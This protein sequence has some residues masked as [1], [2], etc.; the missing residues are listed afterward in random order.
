MYKQEEPEITEANALTVIAQELRGIRRV[1]AL[2]AYDPDCD[3]MLG[4]VADSIGTRSEDD[5]H[6]LLVRIAE[7]L[8]AESP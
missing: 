5:V 1:L 7:A 2:M 6:S 3:T 8:E 4:R